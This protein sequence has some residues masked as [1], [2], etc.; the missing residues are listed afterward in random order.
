M[1]TDFGGDRIDLTALGFSRSEFERHVTIEEDGFVINVDEAVIRVEVR[2][3]W[4]GRTSSDSRPGRNG[5][6]RA[7]GCRERRRSAGRLEWRADS[8]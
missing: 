6:R 5:C 2:V 8:G 3:E 7:P 4:T 1:I